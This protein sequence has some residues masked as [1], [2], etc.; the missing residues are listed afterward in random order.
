MSVSRSESTPNGREK[1]K[2]AFVAG[3]GAGLGVMIA[4][5]LLAGQLDGDLQMIANGVGYSAAVIAL[6]CSI[7][8]IA[9]LD[10][11][12]QRAHYVAWYWGGSLGLA[13]MGA[14]LLFVLLSPA[15]AAESLLLDW[16]GA[17]Q[18]KAGFLTGALAAMLLPALGYTIWWLVFWLRRR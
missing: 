16:W 9:T 15:S 12:A 6:A 7:G 11:F 10:E 17:S 14:L 18:A 1:Q 5:S 13:A 3:T 8:W 2:A 4:V